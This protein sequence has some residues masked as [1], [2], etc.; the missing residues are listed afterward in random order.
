MRLEKYEK[1]IIINTVEN[2]FGMVSISLFGSR[3]DNSKK[4][5]DIDLFIVPHENSNLYEKKIRTLA[6]L[7]R[8][9]HKPVDIIVHK[10][11]NRSIEKEILKSYVVLK[12]L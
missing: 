5:G 6:K 9:L 12:T 2:I 1:D 11:F 3:V 7:E 8:L 4:G 10:N